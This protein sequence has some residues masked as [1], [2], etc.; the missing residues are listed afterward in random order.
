MGALYVSG[1]GGFLVA[2]SGTVIPKQR[3]Q[4]GQ[5]SAGGEAE[6]A[7]G[8]FEPYVN[9]LWM[10]AY[11]REES[12][13]L[14]DDANSALLG[15]GMRYFGDQF[16]GTEDYSTILGRDDYSQGTLSV[17]IRADF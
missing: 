14:S 6:Y 17:Q 5:F 1:T 15:L 3:T 4:F 2:S 9:A 8:D 11:E 12:T 13:V 10:Y 7:C 16:S